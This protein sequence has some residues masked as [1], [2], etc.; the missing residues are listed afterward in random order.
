MKLGRYGKRDLT[1][2]SANERPRMARSQSWL[3]SGKM[4]GSGTAQRP[5]DAARRR[6]VGW[7]RPRCRWAAAR[8]RTATGVKGPDLGRE[9]LADQRTPWVGLLL[10]AIACAGLLVSLL[11]QNDGLRRDSRVA[12]SETIKVRHS[13]AHPSLILTG[14]AAESRLPVTEL[15]L[16]H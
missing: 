7:F 5:T 8:I 13:D 12:A 14:Q 4:A 9:R 11:M 1:L 2:T 15:P 10:W 6:S 16:P 3:A